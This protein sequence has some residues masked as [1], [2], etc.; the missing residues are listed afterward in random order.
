MTTLKDELLPL[1]DDVRAIAGELGFRPYEVYVRVETHAGPRPGYGPRTV[2]DTRLLVGG[3]NP[4]VR[5][6]R[7]K[8]VI[9]GTTEST[10][11]VYEIGPVTPA[12]GGGGVSLDTLA[13]PKT[14]TPTTIY[15]VI[16]GPGMPATGLL[17]QRTEDDVDRP[18]RAVV[19][20]R[21]AGKAA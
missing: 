1:V 21:S 8:D 3:Q 7:S 18:L 14:S 13:P 9:A 19:R 11:A 6:I 12:F 5:E 10:D 4:K 20:V 2:T 16:K 17:C 15:Y